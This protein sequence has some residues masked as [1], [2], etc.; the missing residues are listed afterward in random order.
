MALRGCGNGGR[1]PWRLLSGESLWG[2]ELCPVLSPHEFSS[3]PSRAVHPVTFVSPSVSIPTPSWPVSSGLEPPGNLI[4]GFLC[5]ASAHLPPPQRDLPEDS[6]Q[7]HFFSVFGFLLTCIKLCV[8]LH[9]VCLTHCK[10]N[11]SHQNCFIRCGSGQ[12]CQKS[13]RCSVCI[14]VTN[15]WIFL[16]SQIDTLNDPILPVRTL[17]LR[18]G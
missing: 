18:K 5:L 12:Q 8:Y 1:G 10:L 7:D 13:T 3:S 15:E 9:L 16:E 14:F 2:A 6:S 11:V 17:R 4:Q